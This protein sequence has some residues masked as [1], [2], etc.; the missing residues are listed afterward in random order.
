MRLLDDSSYQQFM[1]EAKLQRT[2]RHRN[3]V[4]F[5]GA[6]VFADGTPF[7]VTEFMEHGS[8]RQVGLRHSSWQRNVREEQAATDA[9]WQ[10]LW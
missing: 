5:Y 8:L 6:G 7:I 10:D 1:D 9:A 4:L 2:L 3:V